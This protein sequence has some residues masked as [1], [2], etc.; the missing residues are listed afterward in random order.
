[1]PGNHEIT[2]K[3]LALSSAAL[4]ALAAPAC[5]TPG[6]SAEGT[7]GT[8]AT[9]DTISQGDK[10]QGAE[11]HPQLVAEFGGA[12]TGPQASYVETVGKT[13][14]VQSGLSNARGD[15]TV[16]LLNSPVN[17]A[18]AIPGGYVYVTRQLTALMNNEAE[19]AGVLGHEVG[20]VAA[21]HSAKRQKAATR[22]SVIGVLGTI[23]S[24]VLLGDST[25]GRLG[26][27]VFSQ[28]S[29]LLTL[30]YSR[31]Q[32][33]E[34]DNLGIEYLRRAGYDPRAMSTVL[35]SLARQNALEA[36]L[37]GTTSQVPEWASTHPDP[38]SRV[39]DAL[40]RAGTA[41]NGM[42][43]RDT[44]LT[45]I[46]GLVYGDDPRQGIVD[47][48]RFTHPDLR[49]AFEAPTGFYMVNGTQSVS[50]SGESGKAEF[51][52]GAYNGSLDAYIRAVFASLTETN[53]QRIV[54]EVI[55]TA[56]VNG[57]PAAYGSARVQASSGPVDL[58]VFAYDFG[59]GKAYHFVTITQ[60]G[61]AGVFNPMFKSMRRISA[62][63]AGA[64]RP[65]VLDVVTVKSGDTV[66]SLSARMAYD[67]A[68]LDRFLVLNGL[69][70]DQ[71]LVP[72]QKVKLVTY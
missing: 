59:G 9:V 36:R 65:R 51:S 54:P 33:L 35:E 53:Q 28:G 8:P 52:A 19:L 62:S 11:A 12:V 10:T 25:F 58:V 48:A 18:F 47:G 14:A 23:L 64:V 71:R 3:A 20:H 45:R 2:R 37:R 55:Q 56:T 60:A 29:Q 26:Q 5:T 15:F 17:N 1:M 39:R 22:N 57:I 49:L 68:K 16:T 13:I 32:E 4:L 42:T 21:R 34:A 67:D 41:A 66:Q 72:G 31:T 50:I 63:E 7:A 27:Q 24:G 61:G 70:A 69:K 38:A 40:V 46:D 44:F 43:N 6:A 30:Q